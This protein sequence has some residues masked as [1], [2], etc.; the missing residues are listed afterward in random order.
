MARIYRKN[1]CI[2]LG[3]LLLP[4]KRGTTLSV[5]GARLSA[6]AS[7]PTRGWRGLVLLGMVHPHVD[8]RAKQR[9]RPRPE[10]EVFA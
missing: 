5:L 1:T 2:A 10:P 7:F 6:R 4:S 3:N 9:K 8:G